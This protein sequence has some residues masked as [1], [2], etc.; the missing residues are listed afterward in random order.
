MIIKKHN[1][2]E[3]ASSE[4]T[5]ESAYLNRRQ[6]IQSAA[7]G[8]I[9]TLINTPTFAASAYQP[10]A[11]RSDAPL[12]MRKKI[13]ER[14]IIT[15]NPV[16]DSITPYN[17]AT[18]YNNF[19]EFGTG[20]SDPSE[21]AGSIKV[22]PWRVEVDGLCEKT[23]S[24]YLE[25]LLKPVTLED[26]IYRFR[27]VEAWSMVVPWLGFPLASLIQR[28]QPK[29]N[30]RFV[31]FTTLKDPK[32]FPNQNSND[33]DWPYIEGLR[34][35]EAM[36]PLTILAVGMYGRS[37]P[38]QNGAPLRLI[39]PWKY[40]FKSIK[41]IVRITFTERAPVTTWLGLAPQEYGFF[42]NVNPQ[43]DHPRW[44]QARE[45]RLPNSLLNPNWKETLMFNGYANEVSSLYKSMDLK[46]FY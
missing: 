6:L 32:Q 42:A 19:Y 43:V 44:S 39:V 24:Y 17:A 27:C 25:D 23:G 34:L 30:A 16:S 10:I 5:S 2:Y 28:L 22:S 36:H 4:I 33:L 9:A 15:A 37:L 26:R 13:T 31:Q 7:I 20:K 14:K 38:D 1:L 18:T 46:K 21:R 40:G 41:S 35:D 8:S 11:E 45:R 29:S 3:P 12:F